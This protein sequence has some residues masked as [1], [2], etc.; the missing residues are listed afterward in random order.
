MY[1]MLSRIIIHDSFI[2]GKNDLFLS[3]HVNF[4][5]PK[6]ESS[7]LTFSILTFSE[8]HLPLQIVGE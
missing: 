3:K 5:K 2:K 7:N 4:C 8:N 1:I 6:K